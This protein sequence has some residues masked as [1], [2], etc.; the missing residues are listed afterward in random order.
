MDSH[1]IQAGLRRVH[2]D[3]GVFSRIALPGHTLRPYQTELADAVIRSVIERRGRSFAA[4]FSRQSGKDEALAQLCTFLLS[5]Y[6]LQGGSIVIALPSLRPQ[7]LIARDRLLARLDSPLTRPVLKLREGTIVEVGRAS[8]RYLSAAPHANSRGNTASLLLVANEAQD[9]EP[10]TWDAVFAPMAASANA[11]T[12]FLGTTWT[13]DTLLARQ[14]RMLREQERQDGARRVFKVDWQRVAE[15]LPD[16]GNYV[17]GQ[18]AQLGAQHPFIRT[19]YEL[20]ELDGDGRLFTPERLSGLRGDFPALDRPSKHDPPGTAYAL[21]VDV[22]GE[23]EDGVEGE[24]VR[25]REPRRDSTAASVVRIIPGPLPHYQV[26]ARYRWTG[27]RHDQLRDRLVQ[28]VQ[29]RWRAKRVVIDAT[30][31]GAGLASFLRAELGERIV[32]PFVFSSAS[33]SQLAWDFLGLL[34]GGRVQTFDPNLGADPEQVRLDQLCWQQLE[35][36]RYSVLPGPG[37]LMRWSV[38]DDRLHDDLLISLAMIAALNQ[39]DWRPRT[40]RGS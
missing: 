36:C 34:D 26:V 28:L 5:R 18:I 7:G 1:A 15:L 38:E 8:A 2:E 11:T 21:T 3:I 23:V 33:K 19:E 22:A 32:T 17:R 27:T 10:D 24:V 25:R 13:S 39:H 37:R 40:A 20:E 31:V 4:V 6:R 35:A 16:Y 14:M 29:Q 30:G 9:I 12:L